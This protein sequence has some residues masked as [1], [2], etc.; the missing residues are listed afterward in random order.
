MA[1]ES[2][3]LIREAEQQAQRMVEDAHEQANEAIA[4]AHKLAK[5]QRE[6]M[7]AAAKAAA[8]EALESSQED[9]RRF[10]EDEAVKQEAHCAKVRAEAEKK[11]AAAIKLVI[12]RITG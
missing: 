8:Q 7:I 1:N 4:A 9:G 2:V 3:T 11:R 5:K 10:A 12:D 6:E